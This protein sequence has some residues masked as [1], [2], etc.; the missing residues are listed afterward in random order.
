[1][2][3]ALHDEEQEVVEAVLWFANLKRISSTTQIEK[4]FSRLSYV[5]KFFKV[6]K[7]YEV[8]AYRNDQKILRYW[9]QEIAKSNYG[10][11]D[12]ERIVSQKMKQ[13][14]EAKL[15][16]KNGVVGYEF[17]LH[18]IEEAVTLGTALILDRK[19]KLTSRL[20]QCGNPNCLRL[21]LNLN[22]KGRPNRHCNSVCK[23]L[24][25][26]A[27]AAERVKRHRDRIRK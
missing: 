26:N 14:S 9:L 2:A 11:K 21:N 7:P 19:R 27:T 5:K 8:D 24:F 17:I 6:L 10:R 18:G 13:V 12:I 23:K 16:F 15:T 4:R 25:D 3:L 20:K 1:M 22:P